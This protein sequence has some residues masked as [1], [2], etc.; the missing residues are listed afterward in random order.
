MPRGGLRPGAGGSLEHL[1]KPK[2]K[3]GPTQ[4]IRVPQTLTKQLLDYA[5]KL[6]AGEPDAATQWQEI[7]ERAERRLNKALNV[8]RDLKAQNDS[9]QDNNPRDRRNQEQ[10]ISI[11]QAALDLRA[12]A[13]GAIKAEIRKALNLLEGK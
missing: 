11:L 13:G 8:L 6:D 2:W 12:N 9:S 5:H 7:A 4:T 3:S 1:I 10:A